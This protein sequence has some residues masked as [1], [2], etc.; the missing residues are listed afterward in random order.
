MNK[1]VSKNFQVSG[2]DPPITESHVFLVSSQWEPNTYEDGQELSNK[3]APF[4]FPQHR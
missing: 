3:I 1:M 4:Y 2:Y